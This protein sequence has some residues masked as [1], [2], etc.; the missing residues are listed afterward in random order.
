MSFHP[1][2]YLF[3]ELPP[4]V[5]PSWFNKENSMNSTSPRYPKTKLKGLHDVQST[6]YN[7]KRPPR[8]QSV[9]GKAILKV[10][11]PSS[12]DKKVVISVTNKLIR[13]KNH[14]SLLTDLLT[15]SNCNND[16][17]HLAVL[18]CRTMLFNNSRTETCE[19]GPNDKE[20]FRAF[21]K[22]PC[23]HNSKLTTDV[24]LKHFDHTGSTVNDE[25]DLL[26]LEFV[27]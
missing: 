8:H 22:Y 13:E 21:Q 7:N 26:G 2:E 5:P 11:T 23:K 20:Y 9:G 6:D 10:V 3:T 4:K 12:I 18:G 24:N 16:S 17:N 14:R 25:H 19:A 1:S 27:L 15:T